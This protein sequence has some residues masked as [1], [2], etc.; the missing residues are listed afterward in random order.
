MNRKFLYC[1]AMAFIIL[2]MLYSMT[3]AAYA[4]D[5]IQNVPWV[6]P[7][8]Y[9]DPVT[10][11]IREFRAQGMNDTQITV[12]LA[13]LGMGWYPKTG[14]T[15]I[16]TSPT[17]EELARTPAMPPPFQPDSPI[18]SNFQANQ[19]MNTTSYSYT[20]ISLDMKP[21]SIAK[22]PLKT[23]YHYVTTHM[24]KEISP[25]Q[26]RWT[27]VG[28]RNDIYYIN[29]RY[30]TYDNDEGYWVFHGDKTDKETYDWYE[31]QLT[32]VH[33]SSGW[34]YNIFIKGNFVRSG[35]LA[36][37]YNTVDTANEIFS[38]TGLWVR[39][40]S[41]AIHKNMY[42]SSGSGWINWNHNVGTLFWHAPN[43]CPISENHDDLSGTW[44]YRTFV[45][46]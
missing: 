31:I 5:S 46:G 36:Y 16:G 20:A 28:V 6:P 13:K 1:L 43:P 26:P 15:W 34:V 41:A 21:G 2:S 12:E 33:D 42:L 32:G 19:V 18:T 29:P 9:V 39:D 25:T 4:E 37:Y 44:T 10:L 40:T 23:L 24:G 7:K 8:D 3:L 27:E 35:H 17:P 38:D 22:G 11:K 14:A 45:L 30:Y